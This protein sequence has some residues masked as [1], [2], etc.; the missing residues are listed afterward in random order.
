MGAGSPLGNR[1]PGCGGFEAGSR[2][3]KEKEKKKDNDNKGGEDG[4]KSRGGADG[5][6]GRGWLWSGLWWGRTG[7]GIKHP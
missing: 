1:E 6:G 7:R 3:R 4:G 2:G 5:V